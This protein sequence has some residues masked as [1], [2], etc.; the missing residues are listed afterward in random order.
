MVHEIIESTTKIGD[1]LDDVPCNACGS[2]AHRVVYRRRYDLDESAVLFL[3]KFRSAGGDLLFDQVVQCTSCGLTFVSPRLPEE[4]LLSEYSQATIK[5]YK[6]QFVSQNEGRE[7]AF[8]KSQNHLRRLLPDG[9]SILDIGT[10]AGKIQGPPRFFNFFQGPPVKTLRSMFST[11]LTN[12]SHGTAK[13]MI[14]G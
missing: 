8:R 13:V 14:L 1:I 7:K 2:R 9:G 6:E 5:G 10:A 4:L 11:I 3:E 12:R